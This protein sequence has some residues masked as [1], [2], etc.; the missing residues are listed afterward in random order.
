[1]FRE[2]LDA[3]ADELLMNMGVIG[4]RIVL[5]KHL[6]LLGD[7]RAKFE[8]NHR[9]DIMRGVKLLSRCYLHEYG[10]MKIVLGFL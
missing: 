4:S 10:L 3:T 8:E 1:M 2:I 6:W 5:V 9:I 7:G